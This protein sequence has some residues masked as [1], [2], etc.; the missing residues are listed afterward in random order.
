MR[1]RARARL[2]LSLAQPQQLYYI[3][4]SSANG[5]VGWEEK[6][7]RRRDHFPQSARD[8]SRSVSHKRNVRSFRT[9][10]LRV[11]HRGIII[12]IIIIINPNSSLDLFHP[13]PHPPLPHV[14]PT[15][16]GD[17]LHRYSGIRYRPHRRLVSLSVV[18]DR[19]V[20]D[21]FMFM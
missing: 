17:Q 16:P 21:R 14:P 5:G 1:W 3:F 2:L 7:C 12:I 13:Y 19:G 11:E 20:E 18:S 8:V 15:T 6:T 4:R 9:L 10:S